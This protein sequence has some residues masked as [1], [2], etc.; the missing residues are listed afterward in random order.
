M[1]A[2]AAGT[3]AQRSAAWL[4]HRPLSREKIFLIRAQTDGPYGQIPAPVGG[5][6]F[7][8]GRYG[9]PPASSFRRPS[10]RETA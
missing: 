8:P 5:Y 1:D 10:F 7:A 9:I 2:N 4:T 6:L 3:L